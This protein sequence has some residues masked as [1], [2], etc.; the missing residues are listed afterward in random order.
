M[1]A[2]CQKTSSL[3]RAS[4]GI[5]ASRRLASRRLPIRLRLSPHPYS[6]KIKVLFK[7]IFT[8]S[9]RP[10]ITGI[11]TVVAVTFNVVV[12]H[13]LLALNHFHSLCVTINGKY[14]NMRQYVK[15]DL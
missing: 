3:L 15:V 8:D 6:S 10:P 4:N 5:A 13:D 14:I 9:E 11:R 1:D 7:P 12:A 2:A